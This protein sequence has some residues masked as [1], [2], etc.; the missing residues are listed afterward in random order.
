MRPLCCGVQ[1]LPGSS[2]LLPAAGIYSCRHR[3]VRLSTD[4]YLCVPTVLQVDAVQFIF[5]ALSEAGAS[6]PTISKALMAAFE[7][8]RP[9][10]ELK[11]RGE[12]QD[13]TTTPNNQHSSTYNTACSNHPCTHNDSTQSAWV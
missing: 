5:T 2:Q 9:Y 10:R 13:S 7:A 12:Q 8:S 1:G 3:A 6:L 11:L 4:T